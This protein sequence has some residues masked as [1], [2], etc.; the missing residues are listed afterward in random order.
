MLTEDKITNIFRV[1]K[2]FTGQPHQ[3]LILKVHVCHSLSI[4]SFVPNV[5]IAL[6]VR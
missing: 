1:Y 4:Y 2:I 5:E 3:N 6:S